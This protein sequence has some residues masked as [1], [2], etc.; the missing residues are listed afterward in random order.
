[1]KCCVDEMCVDELTWPLSACEDK[2]NY[3]VR[4]VPTAFSVASTKAVVTDALVLF[5]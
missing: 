3:D 2:E 5:G 4:K 1:M